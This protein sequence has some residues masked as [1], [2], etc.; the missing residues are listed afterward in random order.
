[1]ATNLQQLSGG[2]FVLGVGVGWAQQEFA[3]LNVPFAARGRLTDEYL[4]A[5]RETTSVPI[6]VGGNSEVGIRRAV[7]FGDAWHPLRNT[8]AWLREARTTH[9]MPACG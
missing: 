5:L 2:R 4:A 8:L 1:M 9:A 3:A 6:W 7:R